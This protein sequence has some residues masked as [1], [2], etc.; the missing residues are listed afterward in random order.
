MLYKCYKDNHVVITPNI[1]H[2]D[3]LVFRV[4]VEL[5]ANITAILYFWYY[6]KCDAMLIIIVFGNTGQVSEANCRICRSRSSKTCPTCPLIN[7]REYEL[8]LQSNQLRNKD[9]LSHSICHIKRNENRQ[10]VSVC[11]I[12]SEWDLCVC[13]FQSFSVSRNKTSPEHGFGFIE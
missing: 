9:Q 2:G 8:V 5:L 3:F 1:F 13:R 12:I 4:F 11:V 10:I 6:V 7:Q